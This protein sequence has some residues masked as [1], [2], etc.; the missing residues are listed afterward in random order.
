MALASWQTSTAPRALAFGLILTTVSCTSHYQPV[1][2]PRLSVVLED[3][4][5]TYVR[6]GRKFKHGITGGGLVDAVEDDPEA[7]KA[8]ETF[9][10]RTTTGLVLYLVGTGCLLTGLFVGVGTLD[11]R[12]RNSD[13][14]ALAAGGILCGVAGLLTGGGLIASGMPYQYDAINIYNDNLERRRAIMLPPP[15]PL[16][17]PAPP[18]PPGYVPYAPV[19]VP[20]PAPLPLPTRPPPPPLGG[21]TSGPG[22]GDAGAPAPDAGDGDLRQAP[23]RRP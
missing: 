7:K 20:M 16:G 4:A 18:G 15:G 5:P 21:G 2:G 19:P 6:D 17:P 3:G 14:D 8:A 1:T 22:A 9:N 10:S 13:R 12:D 11:D 23:T